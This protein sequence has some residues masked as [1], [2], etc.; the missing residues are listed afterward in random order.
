MASFWNELPELARGI[1]LP[2]LIV[3]GADSP[4]GD[5][6]GSERLYET[7][8]SQDKTLKLYDGLLHEIFNEPERDQVFADV[9]SWLASH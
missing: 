7:V 9:A 3:A 5:G 1:T 4:L 2:V 6:P 8:S